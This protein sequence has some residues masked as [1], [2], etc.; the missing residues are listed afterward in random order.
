MDVGRSCRPKSYVLAV[1]QPPIY[2]QR[3]THGSGYRDDHGRQFG[4]KYREPYRWGRQPADD[5]ESDIL[6]RRAYDM[7]FGGI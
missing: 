7:Q 3:V 2:D 1:C 5:V 4:V 6:A